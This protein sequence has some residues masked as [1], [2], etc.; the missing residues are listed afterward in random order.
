MTAPYELQVVVA[1]GQPD[2]TWAQ[3]AGRWLAEGRPWVHLVVVDDQAEIVLD[4]TGTPLLTY[5]PNFLVE[6]RRRRAGWVLYFVDP[7]DGDRLGTRFIGGEPDDLN[8]ALTHAQAWLAARPG[9]LTAGR[10]DSAHAS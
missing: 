8:R 4:D 10:V 2:P 6:P 1:V 5:E 9:A 3:D 7:D